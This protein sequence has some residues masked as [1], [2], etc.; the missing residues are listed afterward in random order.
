MV[1]TLFFILNN[2]TSFSQLNI[3]G[4]YCLNYKLKDFSTCYSFKNGIFEYKDS[5]DIAV[6]QYGKGHYFIKNDSLILNYDL[7]EVKENSYHTS[8]QYYNYKNTIDIKFTIYNFKKEPLHDLMVCGK[9]NFKCVESNKEG[10]AILTFKKGKQK[11][12]IEIQIA[13]GNGSFHQFYVSSNANHEIKV[14]MSEGFSYFESPK[15]IKNQIIKCKITA[16]GKDTI[17]LSGKY[18]PTLYKVKN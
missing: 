16:I 14:Y 6:I 3:E 17:K 12:K 10:K 13:G 15:P 18:I 8:K 9:P 7:T 2:L 5:G 4:K 1:F 11:D